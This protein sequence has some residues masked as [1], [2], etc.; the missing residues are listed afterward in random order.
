MASR[1]VFFISDGTGITAETLGHSLMTQFDEIEFDTITIPY[2]DSEQK[3]KDAIEKVNQNYE[4]T[5][6][7]PIIFATL[8]APEIRKLFNQ[9]NALF[10]DLFN[11]FLEPVERELKS[12]SSYTV[13]KSHGMVD[14]NSYKTRIDAVNYALNNDDGAGH[15]HYVHADV[16]LLGVSRCGKTPTCLYL[17]LQFGIYAANYPFTLD[18]MPNIQL[19]DCLAKHRDKLFGLTIDVGHLQQIRQ[20]RRANTPYSSSTQCRN[21]VTEVE[22]FFKKER[23]D[24][25][26]TTTRSIEEIAT[27]I[28][29]A[30]KLERRL[31]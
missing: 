17:A 2:I 9:T 31:R 27:D 23:I 15:H 18:D 6:Q 7:K 30:K 5:Q 8:V 25:L 3:A 12:K 4:Q 10:L 21:E 19:P 22:H 24:F 29:T 11:S 16:I 20:E 26:N 13:G 14:F 1:T 28:L